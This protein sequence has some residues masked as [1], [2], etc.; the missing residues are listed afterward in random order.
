M[1]R[2]LIVGAGGFGRE[3][4]DWLLELQASQRD[5][6]FVGGFLD[7]NPQALAGL[8]CTYAIVDTLEHYQPLVTDR[9]LCAIGT[10][11]TRLRVCAA[12]ADKGAVFATAIQS[13]A[14]VSGRATVAPGCIIGTGSS[15]AGSVTVGAH[16]YVLAQAVVAHDCVIGAGCNISPGAVLSGSCVVG[17]GVMIGSNATLLPCAHLGDYATVGAGSVVLRSVKAGAIVMGVPAKQIGGF[18]P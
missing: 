7:S 12:L 1:K 14:V 4:L 9:L 11:R 10:P 8:D 16:S 18:A 5:W 15:T 17:E 3:T 2:L 13:G 6:D